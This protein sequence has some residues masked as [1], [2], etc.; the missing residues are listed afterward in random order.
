M[1]D[2]LTIYPVWGGPRPHPLRCGAGAS[3][4]RL[5]NKYRVFI[6]SSGTY[7]DMRVIGNRQFYLS[8]FSLIIAGAETI[9][10]S[11]LG[12]PAAPGNRKVASD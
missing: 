7:S 11:C 6:L 10:L 8:P 4:P 9:S 2:F 1:T 3:P 5:P 12:I